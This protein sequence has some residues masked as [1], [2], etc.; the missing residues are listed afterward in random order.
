MTYS[1]ELAQCIDDEKEL[2]ASGLWECEL[3]AMSI[4]A[5]REISKLSNSKLSVIDVAYYFWKQGKKPSSSSHHRHLV[6]DTI[7]Y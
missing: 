5:C 1:T 6:K 7:H 2:E 3:R 4:L